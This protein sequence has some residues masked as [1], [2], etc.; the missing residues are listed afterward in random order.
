MDVL[1]RLNH[2]Q[3]RR[4][5]WRLPDVL[6]CASIL[7][8]AARCR[9]H[10]PSSLLPHRRSGTLPAPI[11]QGRTP[12]LL[13]PVA[14][15]RRL[16]GKSPSLGEHD[17]R[18]LPGLDPTPALRDTVLPDGVS[19]RLMQ[20]AFV[21]QRDEDEDNSEV[22][23]NTGEAKKDAAAEQ[24]KDEAEEADDTAESLVQQLNAML[25]RQKRKALG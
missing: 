12:R 8:Q 11:C 13:C 19:G 7:P 18:R 4:V 17:L 9:G 20:I 23:A 15:L 16:P 22:G 3:P 25:R 24:H 5:A 14:S 21:P 1:P 6:P 10:G 2:Y